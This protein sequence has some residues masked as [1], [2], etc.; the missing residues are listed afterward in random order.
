V[1]RHA[2]LLVVALGAL[3]GPCETDTSTDGVNSA[4]TR[5][6]DCDNGLSCVGGVC[7]P[8]DAG[9]PVDGAADSNDAGGTDGNAADH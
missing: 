3:R 9:V 7:S 6:S 8:P 2:L 1:S 5:T 4:C